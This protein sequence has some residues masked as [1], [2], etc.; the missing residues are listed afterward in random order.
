M[1]ENKEIVLKI[2]F[3]KKVKRIREPLGSIES[4]KAIIKT[5]FPEL[6]N[7]RVIISYQ[8]A[9]KEEIEVSDDEDLQEAFTQLKEMKANI[10]KL[11]VKKI[12]GKEPIPKEGK[13][14]HKEK[15]QPTL[16]ELAEEMNVISL[17]S[18]KEEEERQRAPKRE[19]EPCPHHHR[20]HQG[21]PHQKGPR[22]GKKRE[23]EES[24]IK[25][26]VMEELKKLD[27]EKLKKSRENKNREAHP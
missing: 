19:K 6:E 27:P 10:L 7:E 16:D 13:E 5:K 17:S 24:L 4:T 12:K 2:E 21:I 8:D 23:R 26:I 14:E 1:E 25:E 9:E 18:E 22:K 3:N 11:K 15:P 20:K